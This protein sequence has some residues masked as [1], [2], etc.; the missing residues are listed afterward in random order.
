M[1]E[2]EVSLKP[3]E[4]FSEEEVLNNHSK[5]IGSKNLLTILGYPKRSN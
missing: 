5:K 2:K 1:I 4:A 3:E